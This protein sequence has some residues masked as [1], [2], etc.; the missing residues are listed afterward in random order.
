MLCGIFKGRRI[1]LRRSSGGYKSL[2]LGNCEL[3]GVEVP[4]KTFAPRHQT[5]TRGNL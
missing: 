5:M 1:V 3:P 4:N 2:P